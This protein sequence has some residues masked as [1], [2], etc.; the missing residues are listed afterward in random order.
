MAA[1]DALLENSSRTITIVEVPPRPHHARLATRVI[2]IRSVVLLLC[3]PDCPVGQ[4]QDNSNQE[5]C[6]NCPTSWYQNQG[7]QATCKECTCADT[8]GCSKHVPAGQSAPQYT[9]SNGETETYGDSGVECNT[10]GDFRARGSAG[11]S[12]RDD[13]GSFEFGFDFDGYI[14]VCDV[15][16][17]GR[18]V[19]N[20]PAVCLGL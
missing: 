11:S 8:D 18:A 1:E 14:C 7:G 6:R 5:A 12:C 16:Y 19:R 3:S 13:T 2:A 9:L 10:V 4:Y 17:V 20:G 15:G